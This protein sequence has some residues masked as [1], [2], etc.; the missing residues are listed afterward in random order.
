MS[1]PLITPDLVAVDLVATDRDDATR[2]LI[3]LLAAAGRVTDADGFH[4]DVRAREAQMATGMPGGIGLPHA[5]S[6]HVTVPS[7]A[8]GKVAAGV[9]FGAPDGPAT[10]VFLIAAP[11]AGDGDHLKILAALAR[12]LVHE[13]FRTSLKEAGDAETVAEIVTREVVPS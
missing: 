9:D 5:R 3:D 6:S 1:T 10:L 12:R 7:L 11:D 8:V 13:S 4:A 2:Q